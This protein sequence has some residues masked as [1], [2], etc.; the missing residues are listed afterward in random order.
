M[1]RINASN[2]K[3]MDK[4][5]EGRKIHLS[6]GDTAEIDNALVDN[7]GDPKFYHVKTGWF[8]TEF[9]GKEVLLPS[10][11]VN[12]V[13]NEYNSNLNKDQVES[14][15][16]WSDDTPITQNVIDK[17]LNRENE[18]EGKTAQKGMRGGR[19]MEVREERP[20]LVKREK[21]AGEVEAGKKRENIPTTTKEET[22]GMMGKEETVVKKKGNLEEVSGKKK[23]RSL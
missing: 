22:L 20:E 6:D 5:W 8:G 10:D 12:Q 17:T 9:R 23:R 11:L 1:D 21:K 14:F 16:E 3:R 19:T 7:S 2:L 13:E 4:P 15:P 18:L